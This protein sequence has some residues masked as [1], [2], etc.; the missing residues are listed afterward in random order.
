[1]TQTPQETTPHP[2]APAGPPVP[3]TGAQRDPYR[4]FGIVGFV[5][6][7]FALLNVAG[8][9]ISLIALIRSKRAGFRNGFA[10]AG[11]V[12]SSVGVTITVLVVVF[13]VSALVGAAEMCASLGDGVHTVGG[14]TYTCTPTSFHVSY[15]TM[16]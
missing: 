9:A 12:I 15:G 11:T 16:R 1:M 2:A 10:V 8:L 3:S 6:S 14:A 13:A 4:S 7:F 5:L